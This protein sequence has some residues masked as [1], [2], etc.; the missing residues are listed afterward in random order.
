M[1]GAASN[2]SAGE[3]AGAGEAKAKKGYSLRSYKAALFKG[4]QETQRKEV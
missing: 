4:D 1:E 3:L 2:R